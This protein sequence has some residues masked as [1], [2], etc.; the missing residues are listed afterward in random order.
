MAQLEQAH[1]NGGG[2]AQQP[3]QVGPLIQLAVFYPAAGFQTLM[4]VFAQ[5]TTLVPMDLVR[6]CVRQRRRQA[7]R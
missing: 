5:P 7:T 1:G 6:L 4:K 2:K 3:L